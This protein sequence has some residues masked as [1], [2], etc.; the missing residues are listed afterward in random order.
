MRCRTSLGVQVGQRSKHIIMLQTTQSVHR[1]ALSRMLV[2]DSE[3]AEGCS[4]ICSISHEVV[5]PHV[6]LVLRPEPGAGTIVE[7]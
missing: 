1:R 6:V 2:D 5:K 4:I 3:H 7:P